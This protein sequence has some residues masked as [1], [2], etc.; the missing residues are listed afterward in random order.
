MKKKFRMRYFYLLCCAVVPFISKAQ[1]HADSV[2]MTVGGKE[3]LL[4][5]FVYMAAKNNEVDLTNRKSLDAYVELFKNFKLKVADA[6]AAGLDKTDDFAKEYN[7]YKAEL[8]S[9]YLSDAQ[10]E[11]AFVRKIYERGNEALEL[12]YI[13]FPFSGRVVTKDTAVVYQ[14]AYDVYRRILEGE[15]FDKTGET[16]E[17]TEGKS[18]SYE[19]VHSLMPLNAPKAFD[20]IAF[21]LGEGEISKP[22]RTA[23]GYFLIKLHKRK[24]N[25]EQVKVAHILFL[26]KDSTELERKKALE[27][28][29]KVRDQI[30]AG[31]DFEEL[32]KI[33]SQDSGTAIKGGVMPFIRRGTTVASFEDAAFQLK[34]SGDV[35][36]VVKTTF[37]Y[38]IIKLLDRQPRSSF[39]EEKK[40]IA[41][42]LKR[43]E[44]NFEYY[45]SFDSRLKKEYNYTFYPGNY[46]ELKRVCDCYFPTD[47]MFFAGVADKKDT[48]FVV[49]AQVLTQNI[50]CAYLASHPF[51]TKNYS[52][53]FMQEVYDLF[54]RDVVTALEKENLEKKY[55]EY[56]HLLQEYRDGILLF[57]I[58]NT[59][60]WGHPAKEQP[61]FEKEWIDE[62]QKKYPVIVNRALLKKIKKY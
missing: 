55:P 3:I 20:N 25:V 54:V 5:E 62:L 45:D 33:Y 12:S 35:S 53:D 24:P 43:G 47:S 28:A 13:L 60:V 59:R 15:D 34:N 18:V 56:S 19:Y 27:K 57:A 49:G 23:M 42:V 22:V 26:V 52:V 36:D 30:L 10:G 39:E 21:A 8:I 29:C 7:R 2:V 44:W 40:D 51:S 41:S 50:F 38:H 46:A 58:S 61:R 11:E 6:E 32:A 31:G 14:K 1:T 48:L 9:S 4:G 16:L 17:E 37:G